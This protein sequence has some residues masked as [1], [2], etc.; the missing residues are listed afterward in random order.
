MDFRSFGAKTEKFRIVTLCHV[1]LASHVTRVLLSHR[2]CWVTRLLS[3]E[4]TWRGVSCPSESEL[5]SNPLTTRRSLGGE[6]RIR[7]VCSDS[8]VRTLAGATNPLL[9]TLDLGPIT[10]RQRALRTRSPHASLPLCEPSQPSDQK[11]PD[12]PIRSFPL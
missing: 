10:S 4:A 7:R 8:W 5:R 9:R 12:R 1:T 6:P 2:S 3:H 11:T